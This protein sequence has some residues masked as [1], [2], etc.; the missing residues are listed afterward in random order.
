MPNELADL[1]N[2]VLASPLGNV[3]ASVGEGVAEAQQALDEAS[4][5]KT[6]E[7]YRES[8]DD[9]LRVLREIGYR[10]TF[11]VLPETIG[12]VNVS[13]RLSGGGA[14]DAS[15]AQRAAIP[16]APGLRPDMLGRL[17]SL[18]KV[19]QVRAYIT[20]VD[21]S[22]QNRY[23]YEAT[24]SAKLTFKIVPVPPPPGVEELRVVPDL[25]TSTVQSARSVLDLLDL[26][27]RF[28]DR[29]GN[30]LADPAPT[31]V[32]ERQEPGAGAILG[33]GRELTL[34]LNIDVT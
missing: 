23:N 8:D 24:A 27:A 18:R 16:L 20:P 5:A 10:P 9:L 25:G 17:D 3:I 13:M 12:E 30:L 22:F 29:A 26:P 14:R 7:I 15:P 32:V 11:Y 6:L 19:Q 33:P 21:A 4:L 1:L 34:H 28:L 2:E 31:S